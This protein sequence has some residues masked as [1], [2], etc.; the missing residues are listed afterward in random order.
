MAK[1]F[2]F[3]TAVKYLRDGKK[4]TAVGSYAVDY[5]YL[6]GGLLR[7]QT[8]GTCSFPINAFLLQWELY[9]G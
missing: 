4:V 7:C 5:Y 8:G 9:N 6:G 2:H 1:A 3:E